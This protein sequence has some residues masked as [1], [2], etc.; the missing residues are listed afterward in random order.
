MTCGA[1]RNLEVSHHS[2]YLVMGSLNMS[3]SSLLNKM[4]D[5]NDIWWHLLSH[6]I[7]EDRFISLLAEILQNRRHT[8]ILKIHKCLEGY[9]PFCY[10][11]EKTAWVLKDII[12]LSY[13]SIMYINYPIDQNDLMMCHSNPVQFSKYIFLQIRI[14][15]QMTKKIA[16]SGL[17]PVSTCTL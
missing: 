9:C 14:L 3:P 16:S 11:E 13:S 7:T 4:I 6:W 10:A 5:S 15:W 17:F 1:G 12:S 8:K 2:Y